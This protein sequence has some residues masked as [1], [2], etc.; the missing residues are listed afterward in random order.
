MS[1]HVRTRWIALLACC[2]IVGAGSA[3]AAD[4]D[5][6]MKGMKM[7]K[8]HD[9]MMEQMM[10]AGAP[11]APHEMMKK[12]EGTWKAT[13]KTWQGPGDPVI[14]EGSADFK[15]ILGG[16]F[17]EQRFTGSMMNQPYEGYGLSG[18]DNTKKAY[19]SLWVDNMNTSTMMSS[20]SYDEAKKTLTFKSTM[21][22]PDGKPMSM[23]MTNVMPDDKTQVFTMYSVDKGKEM[24]M[25]EITYTR[26]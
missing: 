16:R 9:E 13:V 5:D 1:Q 22:G 26:M 10:K 3:F 17:L 21:P 14:S 18:Y 24:K 15:M 8:A 23:R 11:G 7:D 19:T 25:M 4:K 12:C 2:L 20:G 6:A